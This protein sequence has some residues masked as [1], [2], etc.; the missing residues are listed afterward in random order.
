MKNFI[1]ENVFAG[2]IKIWNVLKGKELYV[3]QSSSSKSNPGIAHLF[4][5]NSQNHLYEVNS[6]H[7]IT[8]YNLDTRFSCYKQ[9]VFTILCS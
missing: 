6:H 3:H 9:V 4:Y 2:N 1:Y 5:D 8:L 7:Y